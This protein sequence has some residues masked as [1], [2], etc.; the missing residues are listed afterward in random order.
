MS[1]RDV[2]VCT[3][4][5][6]SPA[7]LHIPDGGDQWPAVILYPDAGGLRDTLRQMGEQLAG[8]GYLT[9][10]PDV[11][12]RNG[13]WA[14]FSMSTVFRDPAERERLMSLVHSVT[15]DMAVRDAGAYI[16]YL[17]SL[18]ETIGSSVGTTGYC[19]GGRLS[20]IVAGHLGAKVAAAA[21]FHGGDI[22]AA[23]D[24]DS[25]HRR[26]ASISATVYVGGATDDAAFPAEQRDRLRAAL[27]DAGVRH[28]IETYPAAHGF[29]V[30]DTPTY[31]P[32]AARTH[33]DALAHLYSTTLLPP[34]G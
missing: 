4:D 11:Y 1:Q 20:L 13:A 28:T 23:D 34:H 27:T 6:A 14:P 5:G 7:S 10:I 2:Q 3:P 26:A 16:D 33:W 9:L 18:P 22:A 24:P 15:A 32:A 21:S 19:M 17:L 25:P 8:L 31:D 30:A 12:Y 29:A